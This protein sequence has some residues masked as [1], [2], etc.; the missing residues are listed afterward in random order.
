[1]TN[2]TTVG[3]A[4]GLEVREITLGNATLKVR[5]LKIKELFAHFQNVATQEKIN[6]AY[7]ISK[8]LDREEKIA[9]MMKVWENL[10]KGEKLINLASDMMT[11]MTG[12]IDIIFMAAQDLNE[13]LTEDIVKKL[14]SIDNVDR[15]A[16]QIAW[17]SGFDSLSD[18]P[19]SPT[20]EGEENK[21]K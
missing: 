2:V 10:P 8:T 5:Q 6:E 17:I 1:M 7:K 15:L 18:S 4:T 3:A 19:D 16:S 20:K 12:V 11:T 21:K 13:G 9:F 14:V